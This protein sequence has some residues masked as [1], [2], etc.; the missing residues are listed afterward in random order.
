MKSDGVHCRG[1][2]SRDRIAGA[3][4]DGVDGAR[5]GTDQVGQGFLRYASGFPGTPDP[6]PNGLDVIHQL[7][8][9]ENI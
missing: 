6:H 1:D 2:H 8:F 4:R 3:C 5:G 9:S 7:A